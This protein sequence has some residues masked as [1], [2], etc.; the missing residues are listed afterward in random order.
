L[1]L[2]Q[3]RAVRKPAGCGRR[4]V[5]TEE[6]DLRSVLFFAFSGSSVP[7]C[8]MFRGQEVFLDFLTLEVETDSL[9][10]NVGTELPLK[11]A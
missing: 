1:R 10:R 11:A 6:L 2:F 9:S 5:H 3:K 4:K 7:T 8:L